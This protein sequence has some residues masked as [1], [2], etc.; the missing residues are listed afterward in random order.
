V[1][2]RTRILVVEDDP[3]VRRLVELVLED[4]DF[5]V[6]LAADG[7]AALIAAGA[8]RPQLI[9]LDYV[10]PGLDGEATAAQLRAILGNIP[11]LLMSAA[12]DPRQKARQVGAA[13]RVDKPFNLDEL[14]TS[15]SRALRIAGLQ[16]D[17]PTVTEDVRPPA[18]GKTASDRDDRVRHQ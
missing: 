11:I 16:A 13:G 8:D 4:M 1:H 10:L 5:D 12:D 14:E 2:G 9:L 18:S 6:A 15:V 3:G 7:R 17:A